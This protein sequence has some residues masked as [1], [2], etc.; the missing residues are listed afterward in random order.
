MSTAV[1]LPR[2]AL[3][4]RWVDAKVASQCVWGTVF[5]R[6]THCKY[7]PLP[8]RGASTGGRIHKTG[9]EW[10]QE[11][12]WLQELSV[13]H[14][15]AP[16]GRAGQAWK[17]GSRGGLG[18]EHGHSWTGQKERTPSTDLHVQVQWLLLQLHSN[19][20]G[21]ILMLLLLLLWPTLPCC[22]YM[23]VGHFAPLSNSRS[24]AST[25]PTFPIASAAP[26]ITWTTAI[27]EAPSNKLYLPH[28]SPTPC[29]PHNSSGCR[30][31]APLISHQTTHQDPVTDTRG[32]M[33]KVYV[34]HHAQSLQ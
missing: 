10:S 8:L 1:G 5:R 6:H 11:L 16:R 30:P 17:T 14:L 32:E 31:L 13:G 28:R 3:G 20:Q 25:V 15:P 22:K 9:G 19:F 34:C 2:K 24:Q 27:H 26:S 12:V 7:C 23:N 29:P 21:S 4:G 18:Q 33:Q